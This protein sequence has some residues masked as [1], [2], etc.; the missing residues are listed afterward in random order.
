MLQKIDPEIYEIIKKEK[1]REQNV[2][3]LIPSENFTSVAVLQALGSVLTNKY[4]EGY[5]HKRYYGGNEFVDEAEDLAIKR[6][7]ELFGAEHVNVQPYSGSPANLEVYFALLKPGDKVLGM[8]LAHG[9]H[10][11]HGHPIN[12]SGK[13][14]N[15]AQY[16]VEE[17]TE[18]LDYDKIR[19]K[20]LEE[21]PK[22][23]VSGAS[24]YPRAIDFKKFQEI[25]EEVGAVSMADIAHIAGLIVA[26]EHQSPFP[27]TDIVT[28]TTHKTLRGPRGAMI[29][30]KEKF[31]KD[32]DRAV[33]PGMQGGPHN[34]VNAAKAVAF[35]EA[36]TPEFR[37][38]I[39]QVVKNAKVLA[40]ELKKYG[41][42]LVTGGTDNHLI[43]IDLTNKNIPGKEA[44]AILDKIGITV[45]K[46]MIPFDKGSP[47][48]PSGIRI[49]TPAI[50]T[51]GMKEDEMKV[52][53]E[54]IN[55]TLENKNNET[56]LE[57]VKS[58]IRELTKHFPLYPELD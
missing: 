19:Q 50:T 44:E 11:T 34:H 47:F 21:K 33:F 51:R 24:A 55:R 57:K 30:C 41:F 42:R 56:E 27:F 1:E 3:E 28:T 16:G 9:G 43:L 25:S 58:Q 4:S 46:N 6:A 10:L 12:F 40:E 14:F 31:A 20:A 18:L 48:D 38:Y 7:K 15:F 32:I 29:M 37:E 17:G 53:A 2:L 22:I 45:N 49:G 39:R 52:I 8:N 26:G 13:I 54:W 5:S 23:I 35:K 36:S